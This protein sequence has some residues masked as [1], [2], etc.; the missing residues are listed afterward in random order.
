MFGTAA[1][2]VF[3]VAALELLLLLQPESTR[4]VTAAMLI[5]L[6]DRNFFLARNF[7]IPF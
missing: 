2:P 6:R 1:A 3:V 5:V 4:I 7:I